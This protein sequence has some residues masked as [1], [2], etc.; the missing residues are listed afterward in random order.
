[1]FLHVDVFALDIYY[2]SLSEISKCLN[3]VVLLVENKYTEPKWQNRW[4]VMLQKN[5]F[6]Q[7]KYQSWRNP[8]LCSTP[9]FRH[10]SIIYRDTPL[11]RSWVGQTAKPTSWKTNQWRWQNKIWALQGGGWFAGRWCL[12]ST[13]AHTYCFSL[14][15]NNHC[16]THSGW[17]QAEVTLTEACQLEVISGCE[18]FLCLSGEMSPASSQR[19][20]LFS[21]RKPQRHER[22]LYV[23][24]Q[25]CLYMP[26]CHVFVY[27]P[28]K[29]GPGQC[30]NYCKHCT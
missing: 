23:L 9:V 19:G 7:S 1:M 14:L 3:T 26:L 20:S 25:V 21:S 29:I 28:S 16:A 11:W 18:D 24:C 30:L 27:M 5:H 4:L 17:R 22:L 6:L 8:C 2:W 12:R 15:G 10:I 13:Q